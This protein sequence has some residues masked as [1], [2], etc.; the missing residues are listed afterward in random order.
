M[1][2]KSA[3]TVAIVLV[4]SSISVATMA[5]AAVAVKNG[6][7]CAKKGAISV[8]AVKGV[9]KTYICTVNPASV[10]NPN[11]AKSGQT[12]TLKTCISYYAAA[13]GQQDN[14]NQQLPLVAMMS[15]PDK[16]NYTTQLKASQATL[17]QVFATIE[18]NYCKTGL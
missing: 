1:V 5:H 7:A 18:N 10:S 3:I 15:E 16:T 6:V 8:T 13:Q 2:R 12:W 4:L 14:I 17:M 9:K 11:V